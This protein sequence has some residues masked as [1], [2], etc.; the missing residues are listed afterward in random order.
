MPESLRR[1]L[2]NPIGLVSAS[3][4]L[5]LIVVSAIGPFIYVSDPFELTMEVTAPPG[6]IYPLGTDD[7]GRDVLAGLIEGVKVSLFVGCAAAFA[8]TVLGVAI[9]AI[10]GYVGGWVDTVIM[11][12]AEFFQVMPTFILSVLIVS[13][14][15]PGLVRIVIVIALLS[16]PQ[17]ARVARGEVL[18]VSQLDFVDSARCMG[19]SAPRILLG[20]VIPNAIA[21]ALALAT[22][23]MAHAILLEASLSYLGLSTSD[24][25]SWGRMLSIGQHHLFTA[26]W[27]SVFPGLAIFITV[28][29][30]N[31][32]G[33]A[34]GDALNPRRSR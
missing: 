17:T 22:L 12:I 8:A 2:K 27:L 20:E 6:G 30:F 24:I 16:W 19:I 25:I 1:V 5:F 10:A 34:L 23:I 32:L 29:A 4:I 13:L 14:L 7:L 11:R 15:G 9:G 28:L 31:L 3:V 21:P 26:W 18:R 33:D